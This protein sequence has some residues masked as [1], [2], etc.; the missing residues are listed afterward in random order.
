MAVLGNLLTE[1]VLVA[2]SVGW[3]IATALLLWSLNS[4]YA[5]IIVGL[6][7][8]NYLATYLWQ[9]AQIKAQEEQIKLMLSGLQQAPKSKLDSFNDDA[10]W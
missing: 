9:R 2:S 6:Y 7:S 5:V 10:N 8:I 4:K 1:I 3:R